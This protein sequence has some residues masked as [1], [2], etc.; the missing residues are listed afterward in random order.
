[1]QITRTLLVFCLFLWP[2]LASAEIKLLRHPSYYKG[3]VA[4]T[5]L[6]SIWVISEDGS[7]VT[8][9]THH[10]ARH[11]YPRLSP[12]CRVMFQSTR[13]KPVGVPTYGAAIGTGA[14]RLLD[15]SSIRMPGSGVFTAKGENMENYGVQ[16][17]IFADNTPESF[18]AGRDLQIERAIEELLTQI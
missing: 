7:A 4:F 16:P 15:G 14:H 3:T 12:D 6:G 18:L 9:L 17:D 10:K 11:L 1:M 5:Y 2:S 8:R 13:G